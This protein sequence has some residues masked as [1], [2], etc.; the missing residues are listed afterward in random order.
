M[1]ENIQREK[2]PR[3]S[4][5]P[6]ESPETEEG[7]IGGNY[8][9]NEFHD[10]LQIESEESFLT[11]DEIELQPAEIEEKCDFES[12]ISITPVKSGESRSVQ[13]V[14]NQNMGEIKKFLNLYGN[15]SLLFS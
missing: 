6:I 1:S 14:D 9:A 2:S 11:E 15:F 12:E 8:L 7:A 5:E 3:K 10:K 13:V 4:I